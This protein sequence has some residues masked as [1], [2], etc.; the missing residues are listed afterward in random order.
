MAYAFYNQI[1]IQ[2]ISIVS[3]SYQTRKSLCICEW[4][5]GIKKAEI[6]TF[7]KQLLFLCICL[8]GG[9]IIIITAYR[10]D[11]GTTKYKYIIL[12]EYVSW[13]MEAAYNHNSKQEINQNEFFVYTAII[14]LVNIFLLYLIYQSVSSYLFMSFLCMYDMCYI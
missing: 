11:N 3:Q 1:W 6:S 12:I 10:H 13:I 7:F 5:T 14:I 8:I 9:S 2:F 4:E